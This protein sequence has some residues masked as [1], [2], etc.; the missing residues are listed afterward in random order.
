MSA[1]RPSAMFSLGQVPHD[2]GKS[3]LLAD[4][5]VVGEIEGRSIEAQFSDGEYHLLFVTWDSPYEE[6]LTLLLLDSRGRVRD[7]H[8]LG[9]P[10]QPGI[11]SGVT[12]GDGAVRFRFPRGQAHEVGVHSTLLGPRLRVRSAS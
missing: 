12:C 4:G 8:R 3:P 10:L 11:L 9:G 6:E 2:A 5:D 7:R 1:L